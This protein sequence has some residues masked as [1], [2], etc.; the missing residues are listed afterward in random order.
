VKL[1]DANVLLYAI[2]EDDP[3]HGEAKR[4]L[5][6]FLAGTE[7]LGFAWLVVLAFLRVSTRPAAF[8]EPFATEEAVAQLEAWLAQPPAVVVEPTRRHLQLV[9]GLLRDVGTAGNLVTDAHLAALALEHDAT[10]VSFD[11]DFGRFHGVRWTTP[12]A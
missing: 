7:T 10:V 1:V 5:D 2:N 8:A 12:H 3:H 9:A 11:S 4:W 6:S